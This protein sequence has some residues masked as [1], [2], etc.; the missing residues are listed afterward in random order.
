MGAKMS[1]NRAEG[2]PAYEVEHLTLDESHGGHGQEAGEFDQI[3]ENTSV[4]T[5]PTI[6]Q[7]C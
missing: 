3:N 4:S 7:L 6:F 1:S 2:P 5:Y